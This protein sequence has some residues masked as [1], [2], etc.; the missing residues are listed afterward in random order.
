MNNLHYSFTETPASLAAAIV[1]FAA[2]LLLLASRTDA[3]TNILTNPGF[4]IGNA[5]GWSAY[6]RHS[7][8]STREYYYNGGT[9]Y[10]PF[11]SNVLVHGGSRAGKAW[12]SF[13]GGYNV[14]GFYQDVP[15]VA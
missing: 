11:A 7:V 14:N 12:V 3:A 9:N 6:G 5:S 4:E 8:D 1:T 10:P 15:A 2:A 13:T